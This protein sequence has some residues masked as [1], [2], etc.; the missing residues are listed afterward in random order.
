MNRIG[1]ITSLYL[2][3]LEINLQSYTTAAHAVSTTVIMTFTKKLINKRFLTTARKTI[4]KGETAYEQLVGNTRLIRLAG[5]SELTGCDIYGKCEWENPGSSIKDRAALWM[6][7]DAEKK[8]DVLSGGEK[9]RLAIAKIVHDSPNL[10]VLDEPTNH[11]DILTKRALVKALRSY[12]GT[13]VFVSHDR[14]FLDAVANRVLE[15]TS[16]GPHAY[17]G[18]YAEYVAASGH[19]AP[20]MRQ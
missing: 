1:T 9:S 3:L 15:L 6:G 10:L 2:C 5:P 8:V 20:G 18:T 7:K 11:L 17:P 16:E 13:I 12:S 19:A 14:A 4:K